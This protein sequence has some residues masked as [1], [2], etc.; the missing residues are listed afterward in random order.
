MNASDA[1]SPTDTPLRRAWVR[2]PAPSLAHACELT[3]LAREPIHFAALQAEHQAYRAA[4]AGMG[5][6]VSCLPALP[7]FPD[8]VFVEDAA[9]LLDELSLLTRPGVASRQAEP[10]H[11]RAA[12]LARGRP[13]HELQGPACLDGG[14]VLRMGR[15]LLVGLSTRS[16]AEAVRQLQALLQP[17]GYCV[18]GLP[19]GASLH[20]KTAVTALDDETLLLNPAWVDAQQLHGFAQLTV[21]PAEPFA[22]NVLRLPHAWLANAAYPRTLERLGPEAT[23]RGV[24]LHAV[25]IPEFGKAEAGLTCLSLVEP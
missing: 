1:M 25:A 23:R 5:L 9:L 20:L 21:D 8:S 11:L 19:V 12:L 10:R 7:E 18:R 3:H 15:Q 24:A 14:D 17:L 2:E 16:N 13:V 6:Q 22:A 4:L